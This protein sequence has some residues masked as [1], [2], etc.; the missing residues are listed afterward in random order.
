MTAQGTVRLIAPAKV[1]LNL[2]ITGKREDGFHLLD[3]VVVFT[4]FGD[5]IDVSAT[6]EQTDTVIVTGPFAS[7]LANPDLVDQHDN[8]C[9]QAVSAFRDAGGTAAPISIKIAKHIP[10]G[11]GLG[12]GSSDAAA[13]LRHLNAMTNTPLTAE[14]LADIG[15]SLGADVP[16]CLA[17]M[18]QRMTGIGEVLDPVC[19][20]PHGHLVLARPDAMLATADVFRRLKVTGSHCRSADG[21]HDVRQI[22]ARGNDLQAVA[23]ELVPAI[24][25]VLARLDGCGSIIASQ[26]S[27]SGS[28]CF[29]LFETAAAASRAAQELSD[30]GLWAV[31][32]D[33]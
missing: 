25:E 16:V 13:L 12:G 27:G 24:D 11:A 1:N 14:Q 10:V 15:L 19:P 29:G 9:L 6:T 23:T 31:A 20:V 26:M 7:N 2:N 28:A 21:G 32:T 3:S 18:A 4:S 8:I 30:S 17:G 22:I 33:F 5:V